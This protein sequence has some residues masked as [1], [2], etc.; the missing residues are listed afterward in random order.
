MFAVCWMLERSGR[1]AP[2]FGSAALLH[3]FAGAAAPAVLLWNNQTFS[4]VLGAIAG[5]T[6]AVGVLAVWRRR[7][8]LSHG[9]AAVGGVLACAATAAGYLY[10]YPSGPGGGA[11]AGGLLAGMF[12]TPMTGWM[13]GIRDT[14]PWIRLTVQMLAATILGAAAL[15][16][17][18]A[19]GDINELLELMGVEIQVGSG[20]LARIAVFS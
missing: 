19:Y 10:G 9:S 7:V 20:V 13:P 17:A 8:A 16:V 18:I 5:A 11:L 12:L 3:V 4:K 2:A 14:K 6:L 15:G 1:E